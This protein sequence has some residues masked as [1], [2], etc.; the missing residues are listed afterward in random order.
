MLFDRLKTYY[1][2]DWADKILH[3]LIVAWCALAWLSSF[4]SLAYPF[5]DATVNYA[6][7]NL[8]QRVFLYGSSACLLMV[9]ATL[10]AWLDYIPF[11]LTQKGV[12][13][14]T[15]PADAKVTV[16]KY[17]IP[18]AE[19]VLLREV[20]RR[21]IPRDVVVNV[22]SVLLDSTAIDTSHLT[23]RQCEEYRA[24]L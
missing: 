23:V 11:V 14:Y 5:I 9:L 16:G 21:L 17:H 10:P 8:L 20:P 13:K 1:E 3:S 7:L 15:D 2:P 6:S 12:S 24:Q 4:I 18:S 19:H 22:L